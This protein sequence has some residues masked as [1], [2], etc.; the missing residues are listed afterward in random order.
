MVYDRIGHEKRNMPSK[1]KTNKFLRIRLQGE[2]KKE[3]NSLLGLQGD[4]S[5]ENKRQRLCQ[6]P[7]NVTTMKKKSSGFATSVRLAINA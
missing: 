7:N 1:T 6:F 4:L 3:D 2:C 5:F